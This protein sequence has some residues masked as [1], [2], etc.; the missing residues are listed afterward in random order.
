MDSI[1]A[2][3][4]LEILKSRGALAVK[5]LNYVDSF[6]SFQRVIGNIAESAGQLAIIPLLLGAFFLLWKGY[7]TWYIPISF[8]G[9]LAF[10]TGF[11]WFFNPAKYATPFFHLSTGG[12]MIGAFFMATDYVTTPMTHEGML[13]FGLGCG[14]LTGIIRLFGGYPEGVSFAILIMNALTP[15][16]DKYTETKKRG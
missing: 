1:S 5:D 13:I 10:F 11:F 3:T 9:S 15:L 4:P 16:I 12:L 6:E 14:I 8:I 2:A 7:I